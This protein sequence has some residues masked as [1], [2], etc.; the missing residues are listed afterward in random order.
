MKRETGASIIER[1]VVRKKEVPVFMY[2]DILDSSRKRLLKSITT[3]LSSEDF[4]WN[5]LIDL[6]L[7]EG[8]PLLDVFSEKT[9]KSADLC[10]AADKLYHSSL[11][12]EGDD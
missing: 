10:E 7:E 11:E 4:N 3:D 1:I 5:Q 12:L 9:V 8:S 2:E 6:I